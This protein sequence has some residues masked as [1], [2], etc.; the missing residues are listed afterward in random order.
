MHR[1]ALILTFGGGT[2]EVQRDI[3]AAAGLGLPVTRRNL[4]F[5]NEAGR[6]RGPH[7]AYSR[8]PGHGGAAGRG[9]GGRRP[10]RPRALGRP[11][12]AG[13]LAAGCPSRWAGPGSACWSS[14]PCSPRSAAPWPRCPTWPRS[15]S[16]PARWPGSA[17]QASSTGGPRRRP[18]RSH[19]D[20]RPVR[21]GRRDPLLPRPALTGDGRMAALRGKDRRA[22][23]PAG[24]PDAGPGRDPRGRRVPGHAG[25]HGVVVQRQQV[26]DGDTTGRLLLA[27]V[28]LPDDR[29]LGGPAAGAEIAAGWCPAPP[30]A[31]ARCSW[32]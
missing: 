6:T 17:P 18:R 11:G 10:V 26:T 5:R 1:S 22:R 20:R 21:G 13:I 30:W 14:A 24:R 31:C 29:V 25:R 27:G 15:C 32:G 9:R 2:N 7:P 16:A 4:G 3:I 28:E 19:G 12:R 8:P 23:R